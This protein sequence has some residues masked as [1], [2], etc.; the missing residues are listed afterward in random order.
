MLYK[1]NSTFYSMI[2]VRFCRKLFK[3]FSDLSLKFISNSSFKIRCRAWKGSCG[4]LGDY[5]LCKVCKRL[6]EHWGWEE[7][8]FLHC[9]MF[10]EH[11][12]LTDN[13]SNMIKNA[14]RILIC[15]TFF[16]AADWKSRQYRI[17]F[18]KWNISCSLIAFCL[19]NQRQRNI[20]LLWSLIL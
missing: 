1:L 2:A 16:R 12:I 3:L 18:G 8:R 13:L 15:I 20:T 14:E 4:A 10:Y 11:F 17:S 7:I 9:D 6:N 19:A 5:V